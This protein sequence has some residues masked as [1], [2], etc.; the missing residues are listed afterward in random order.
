M[1]G[2]KAQQITIVDFSSEYEASFRSLNEA[3]ITHYFKMEASDYKALDNPQASIINN[4]G[5]IFV[6]LLH[7]E[8]VGVCALIKMDHPDYDYE[9]AK[10][11]VAPNYRGKKIGLLLGQAIIAK[12]KEMG[13]KNLYLESNTILKPA[14]QL[15]QKLGFKAVLGISSPYA[16]CNIQM[17]LKIQ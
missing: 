4:G 17:E 7:N 3:W 11:A 14:I 13:A 16:R 2:Q 9:L 15:Y 1:S 10:M 8:A 6:A 5:H 12:A